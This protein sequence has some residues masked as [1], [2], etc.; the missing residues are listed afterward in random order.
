MLEP[1]PIPFLTGAPFHAFF[2]WTLK[3]QLNVCLSH[4]Q[5]EL[6]ALLCVPTAAW[7]TLHHF[8]PLRCSCL[9]NPRDGGTWWAA[10]YGVTKRPRDPCLPWRGILGPGHTPR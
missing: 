3:T 2:S 10:V 8:P 7:T 1:S 4:T 6:G 5:T 9:E